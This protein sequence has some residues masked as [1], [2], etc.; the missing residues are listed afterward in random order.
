MSDPTVRNLPDVDTE[1]AIRTVEK[2]IQYIQAGKMVIMVD[3]EDRENEGDFVMAAEKCTPEGINFMAMHGRG[4]ICLSLIEERAQ[5][6]GLKLMVPR[7]NNA[8]RFTTAFTTSIEAA[9]GVTTG[10]SAYDR[11]TTGSGGGRR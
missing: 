11:S 6:L 5:Q 7:E 8:S 4:L 10:I 2:A 1:E 3:D 9:E